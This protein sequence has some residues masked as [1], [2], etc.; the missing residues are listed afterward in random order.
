MYKLSH[1]DQERPF[2][3]WIT[4]ISANIVKILLKC[5]KCLKIRKFD[6]PALIHRRI[7][8]W[9]PCPRFSLDRNPPPTFDNIYENELKIKF[10]T[11]HVNQN[12]FKIYKN[13]YANI[14]LKRKWNPSWPKKQKLVTSRQICPRSKTSTGLKYMSNGVRRSSCTANVVRTQAVV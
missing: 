2:D 5:S 6:I 4:M 12:R 7:G 14:R 10:K 3:G 11:N 8:T 1:H 9:K 13:L